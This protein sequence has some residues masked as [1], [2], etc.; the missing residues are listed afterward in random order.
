MNTTTMA[1]RDDEFDVYAS[2]REYIASVIRGREA[3]LALFKPGV[4]P[5]FARE[6]WCAKRF[7]RDLGV[8]ANDDEFLS[9]PQDVTVD[10]AVKDARFQVKEIM[11]DNRRRTDEIKDGL[12]V[13]RQEF[14]SDTPNAMV[15]IEPCEFGAL[16]PEEIAQMVRD[17]MPAY[18]A[19]YPAAADRAALDLLVYVNLEAVTLEEPV[20]ACPDWDGLSWRS[21]SVVTNDGSIVFSASA[22]APDFIRVA[23]GKVS[24][25][26]GVSPHSGNTHVRLRFSEASDAPTGRSVLSRAESAVR[27]VLKSMGLS[28]DVDWSP[29]Q[30]RAASPQIV[31]CWGLVDPEPIRVVLRQFRSQ[32]K[33]ASAERGV[34]CVRFGPQMP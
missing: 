34:R 1:S 13:A 33:T 2:T 22:C 18:V 6:S 9:L 28:W 19:K 26:P 24:K 11:K 23:R 32:L 12:K 31:V 25:N 20:P 27:A 8:T 15:L 16:N 3:T 30:D 14:A 29:E 7:L 4:G 21:V 17:D 5:T 10:V